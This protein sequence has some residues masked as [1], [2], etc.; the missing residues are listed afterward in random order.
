M[1]ISILALLFNIYILSN[2]CNV[3]NV[4]E[5]RKS[6]FVSM[7]TS[8]RELLCDI[9]DILLKNAIEINTTLK[10]NAL[11]KNVILSICEENYGS[12]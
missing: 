3:S 6:C 12:I 5:F 8:K 10:N 4:C 7:P 11:Y 2:S 1:S 9:E